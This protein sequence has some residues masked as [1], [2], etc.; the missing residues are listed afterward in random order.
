MA[1]DKNL[2]SSTRSLSSLLFY[3]SVLWDPESPVL[4]TY[5]Y[6]VKPLLLKVWQSLVASDIEY[7]VLYSLLLQIL[8]Q[9]ICRIL[10]VTHGYEPLLQE[11]GKSNRAS[12]PGTTGESHDSWVSRRA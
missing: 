10:E 8:N 12:G 9:R 1:G 4:D 2:V 11:S 7:Q 3:A 6:Y 5:T